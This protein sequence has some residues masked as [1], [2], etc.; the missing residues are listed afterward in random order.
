[1]SEEIQEGE[2]LQALMVEPDDSAFYRYSGLLGMWFGEYLRITRAAGV[3]EGLEKLAQGDFQ[4][5]VFELLDAEHS[6]PKGSVREI[7]SSAAASDVPIIVLTQSD[8]AALGLFAIREGVAEFFLKASFDKQLFEYRVRNLLQR[9]FRARILQNQVTE[10]VAQ[11]HH[12]QGMSQEEITEL[13]QIVESMK[14]ELQS[15]YDNKI[16]LEKEKNRMQQVFGMY[17]DPKLVDAILKN[18]FSVEQKGIVQDVSVLFAD[19]R[20]YTTLAEKMRPEDVIA[21]L[22]TY[23]TAMTEVIMGFGGMIDK[24]IGDGIMALFGAPGVDP[25]HAE[26]ALQAALEMQMVFELWLPK[27]EET[28]GIRPAMGVGVASGEAVVGN[29]GSFQKISYTAV[30]DTVNLASRL[31]SLAQSGEVLIPAGLFERLND[32][33]KKKYTYTARESVT[34]KGKSGTHAIYQVSYPV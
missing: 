12:A 1:M 6:D 20:G 31:E 5:A 29:V 18:E 15:E 27:W 21:F 19:I 17:V 4:M 23:F 24:Y 8:D 9:E 10:S 22:N 26:N 28:F 16:L 11:F 30:G 34:I 25:E 7:T 13:N 3:S 33:L 32:E 14:R 2:R